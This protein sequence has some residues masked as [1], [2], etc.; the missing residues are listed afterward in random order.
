MMTPTK[1]KAVIRGL[2]LMVRSIICNIALLLF[3]VRGNDAIMRRDG[4]FIRPDQFFTGNSGAVNDAVYER[5]GEDAYGEGTGC[6]QQ[7]DRS[8]L[9]GHQYVLR[10][11][12]GDDDGYVHHRPESDPLF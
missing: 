6:A 9:D 4:E 3:H 10:C 2:S 8:A 5:N 12:H 7:G 1:A 11:S